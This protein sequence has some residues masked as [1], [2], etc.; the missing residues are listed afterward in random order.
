MLGVRARDL[1]AWYHINTAQE[2]SGAFDDYLK[3]KA[4]Y[5]GKPIPRPDFWGGY[6]IRPERIE[7]WNSRAHRM[8]DRTLYLRDGDGWRIERLYP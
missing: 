7:F 5:A 2:M 8:H 6:R 3:L 4:Q 1:L